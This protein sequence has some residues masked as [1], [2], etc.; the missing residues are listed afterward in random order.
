MPNL[1]VIYD[2]YIACSIWVPKT[3]VTNARGPIREWVPKPKHWSHV[4]GG[5]RWWFMDTWYRGYKSYDWKQGHVGGYWLWTI[6][7]HPCPIWW[8]K[9]VKGIGSWQSNNFSGFVHS[10]SILFETRAFNLLFIRQLAMMGLCTFF[11]KD[12][13]T[14][15]WS[16]TLKVSFVG[17]V[18]DGMYVVDFS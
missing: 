15:M 14:L 2:E 1:L 16:K 9:H 8:F 13:V 11:D 7:N 18:E 4:G 3:P 10:E 17:H 12:M 5:F 6:S